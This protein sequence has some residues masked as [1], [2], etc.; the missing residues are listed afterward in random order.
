MSYKPR[1]KIALPAKIGKNKYDWDLGFVA[2]GKY[3]L[4]R[5]VKDK[6]NSLKT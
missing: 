4:P 3:E 6:I 2:F 1:P 5:F